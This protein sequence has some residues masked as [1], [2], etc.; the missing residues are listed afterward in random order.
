MPLIEADGGPRRGLGYIFDST[1]GYPGEGPFPP[2]PH[3]RDVRPGLRLWS[4]ARPVRA[5]P[6]PNV[7][8]ARIPGD[9]G[10]PA[11]RAHGNNDT[12]LGRWLHSLRTHKARDSSK[13]GSSR[14]HDSSVSSRDV[15]PKP[16]S[17]PRRMTEASLS[18]YEG[19]IHSTTPDD[20]SRPSS[21]E[22][23]PLRGE[24]PVPR[25]SQGFA[26]G[27]A[28]VSDRR[29][30]IRKYAKRQGVSTSAL[31]AIWRSNKHGYKV[32]YDASFAR[33]QHFF[34]EM[35]PDSTFAPE[36]I[37]P[38][39]LVAFLQH[40]RDAGATYA[41]LKDASTSIS[42]ACREATDGGIAL[43]DKD[44]VKRFLKSIRIHEPVGVRKQIVPD[45]HDVSALFQEAWDFGPNECLCEGNLKEKLII[46][47]MVDSAARPSD[48][49]RLFRTTKGR[50]SQ[51]RFEGNDMFIRY[52]WS[53]EV[54][55]G[56]SRSNST[57]IYFSKWVKIHGT[58]PKCT[59]T[60]ETM[61]AFLRR[62]SDPELY[63]TVFIPEL[64]IA[65]QPLVYAQWQHGRLQQASVDHISN[66]VKRAIRDKKMGRMMTAHIRGASVSKIVQ[67]VPELTEQALAL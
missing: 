33:F 40:E 46:L 47:L 18:D 10:V 6:A 38:G 52:F 54:D 2:P 44:S 13:T 56:S 39:D 20:I 34:R 32:A 28:A 41:S 64:Q 12:S 11:K 30:F 3:R 45:Y 5:P 24:P 9:L 8:P 4:T 7:I 49:H 31:E 60:V 37:L 25:P 17:Q 22:P 1:L 21:A 61:K 36:H 29:V 66:I 16:P 14:R 51:I 57:N 58:V 43:G 26:N 63:A 27:D 59:D 19:T 67:L 15:A 48:I 42:M 23:T 50:N 53:K 55:P 65:S 62:T 35:K